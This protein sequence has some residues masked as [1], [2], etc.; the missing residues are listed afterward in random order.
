MTKT[1]LVLVVGGACAYAL[2]ATGSSQ[3][4]SVDRAVSDPTVYQSVV[5]DQLPGVPP[6]GSSPQPKKIQQVAWDQPPG[7]PPPGSGTRPKGSER[8]TAVSA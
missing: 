6:T 4:G 5:W 2:L 8:V 3:R 1:N 7:V